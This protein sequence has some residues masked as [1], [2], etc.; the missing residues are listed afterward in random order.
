MLDAVGKQ[1]AAWA[2][3][4]IDPVDCVRRTPCG[5]SAIRS[6]GRPRRGMAAVVHAESPVSSVALSSRVISAR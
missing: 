2:P 3:K 4:A 6:D 5:P 1:V